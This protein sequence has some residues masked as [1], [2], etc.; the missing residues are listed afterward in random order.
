[1]QNGIPSTTLYENA[2]G[3]RK[4]EKASRQIQPG[5]QVRALYKGRALSGAQQ[6]VRPKHEVHVSPT[7]AY[8]QLHHAVAHGPLPRDTRESHSTKWRASPAARR[9]VALTTICT[10]CVACP[11]AVLCR[12]KDRAETEEVS[13]QL[14]LA[15]IGFHVG[16]GETIWTRSA[17]SGI[18]DGKR[19]LCA[20]HGF[21]L[22]TALAGA[23]KDWALQGWRAKKSEVG[24]RDQHSRCCAGTSFRPCCSASHPLEQAAVLL[25]IDCV[26]AE[27]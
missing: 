19:L 15:A 25:R 17:R 13:R 6:L 27:K 18:G 4:S 14:L 16:R 9:S 5:V 3:G 10:V 21:A 22:R 12:T 20:T 26:S 11:A 2:W 24:T 7:G 1:M 8:N 23:S